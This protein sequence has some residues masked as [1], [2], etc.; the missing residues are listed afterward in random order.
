MMTSLK[1]PTV[2]LD[3]SSRQ[4]EYP[5]FT[6]TCRITHQEINLNSAQGYGGADLVILFAIIYNILDES[7]LARCMDPLG[8]CLRE[9]LLLALTSVL[10]LL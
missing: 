6:S 10:L 7:R 5:L 8:A 3:E 4:L 2:F 9:S 1:D